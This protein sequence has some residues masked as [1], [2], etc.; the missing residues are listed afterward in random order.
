MPNCNEHDLRETLRN[1]RGR[2][3]TIYTNSCGRAGDGF[4]GVLSEVD[5][6]SC[7]LIIFGGCVRDDTIPRYDDCDSVRRVLTIPIEKINCLATSQF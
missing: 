2:V 4:T 5:S 6:N 7:K 3:C 1:N